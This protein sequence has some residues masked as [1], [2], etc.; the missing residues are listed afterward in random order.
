MYF[1][2]VCFHCAVRRCLFSQLG[3]AQNI[4]RGPVMNWKGKAAVEFAEQFETV[5]VSPSVR[6]RH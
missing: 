2:P 4:R 5:Q 6:L 1:G 3:E